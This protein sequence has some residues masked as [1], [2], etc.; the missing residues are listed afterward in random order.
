MSDL[1]SKALATFAD[2]Y[3]QVQASATP[4]PTAMTLASADAKGKPAARV[5]LLKE[6]DARGFVFYSHTDGRKG[7]ELTANPQA[8]LL[9]WWPLLGEA[10][11]QVRIEGVAEP[12]SAA[13]ADAYFASRPRMSQIGAWASEQSR[14]LDA[15]STF[16]QR[17][18]EFERKFEGQDVPRPQDWSG[19]RIVPHSFE[20]WFGAKFRL[21][22]RV[23]YALGEDGQWRE[24]MLYP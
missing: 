9:F 15:R 6:F 7:T 16:E 10:G 1:Y 24:R 17:I 14:T 12:V 11:V 22:E 4:E 21:H 18:A 13:E 8:A 23:V 2:L 19:T 5:V 3:A 20:F